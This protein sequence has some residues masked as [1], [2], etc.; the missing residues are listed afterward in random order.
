MEGGFEDMRGRPL[1]TLQAFLSGAVPY[2]SV[3]MDKGVLPYGTKLCIPAFEK[4]YAAAI[5][6][7]VVDTGDAFMGKGLAR[8]DICVA[9]KAES[10]KPLV[11]SIVF[12]VVG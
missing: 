10:L 2:V 3:A 11:N 4:A 9:N 6:F 5:E 1:C 12:A 8:M 7:R